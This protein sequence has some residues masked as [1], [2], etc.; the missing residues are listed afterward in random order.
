MN[1][2]KNKL[3]N[4]VEDWKKAYETRDNGLIADLFLDTN[5][6]FHYG[7][8]EDEKIQGQGGMLKQLE[9]DWS[10]S[11]EGELEILGFRCEVFREQFA[12]IACEMVPTI[13]ISGQKRTFPPLRSTIVVVMDT[14]RWKIAHTHASWPF[15][16]QKEGESFPS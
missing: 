16:A 14:G 2:S 15:D 12:W 11:E 3:K 4:V 9:R 6:T 1:G 8:G 13:T 7:T 5:S 10:Q